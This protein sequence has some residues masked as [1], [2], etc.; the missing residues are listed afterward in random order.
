MVLIHLVKTRQATLVHV[1]LKRKL[2]NTHWLPHLDPDSLRGKRCKEKVVGDG[3]L[4]IISSESGEQGYSERSN[5]QCGEPS[6][7]RLHAEKHSSD[8]N[9]RRSQHPQAGEE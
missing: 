7:L 8:N 3:G 6:L 1:E 5:Q 4:Q 2:F 9:P